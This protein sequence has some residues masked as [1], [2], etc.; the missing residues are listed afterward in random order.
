MGFG[1]YDAWKLMSPDDEWEQRT[2]R[3]LVDLEREAEEYEVLNWLEAHA[4]PPEEE[5]FE[6]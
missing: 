1:N 4:R 6:P 5:D 3:F 2:G